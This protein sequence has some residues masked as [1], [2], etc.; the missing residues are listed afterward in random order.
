[1]PRPLIDM[2][3][4]RFGRWLVLHR[5]FDKPYATWL[6]RC[7]CGNERLLVGR[8]LRTRVTTSCGCGR[9]EALIKH[10]RSGTREHEPWRAMNDR[11]LR[12]R[13]RDYPNYGGRGITI[14]KRWQ[15]KNGF[16]NFYSDMGNCPAGHTLDRKNNSQNYNKANCRWAS[17]KDQNRNTRKTLWVTINGE[18]RSFAEWVEFYGA[19]NY[20]LAVMRYR[21]MGWSAIEAL[22]VPAGQ[23]R[24]RR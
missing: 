2:T 19:V 18:R 9:R 15:G 4:Q 7:D 22:T 21:N 11:C 16:A 8:D 10:G 5:S 12:S 17:H 14:C 24:E 23:R 6:C 3:G 1:M 20:G 13:N